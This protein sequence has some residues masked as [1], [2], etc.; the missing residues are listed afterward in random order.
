[1]RR[2]SVPSHR[3]SR[4]KG[5]PHLTTSENRRWALV[6]PLAV[7]LWVI[8]IILINKNGPADH[9]TG[10]EILAWYKSDSDTI[11]ARR[12]AVHARL[13]R[14]RHSRRGAAGAAR[15]GGRSGQP[16]ADARARGGCDGR[17]R[18][19]AHGGRR[20]CRRDR[21]ERHRPRDRRDLSSLRG[22]LLRG[23]GA[24]CDPAARRC[25]DSRLADAGAAA[26]VGRLQRAR[27]GRAPRS[28]RSDGSA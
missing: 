12:L 7:A 28:A 13:P 21:Q 18:R 16:A 4:S 11:I 26:L 19:D 2:G 27:R 1:M 20:P 25:S 3:P 22:H 9:A 10:S 6:G 17:P 14:L 23:R 5:A 24:R 8:G 15:R